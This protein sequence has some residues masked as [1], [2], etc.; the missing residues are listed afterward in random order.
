MSFYCFLTRRHTSKKLGNFITG[1]NI[2]FR[3]QLRYVETHNQAVLCSCCRRI[4][5]TQDILEQI[6]KQLFSDEEK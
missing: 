4:Q 1:G 2:G 6:T 5:N 3:T